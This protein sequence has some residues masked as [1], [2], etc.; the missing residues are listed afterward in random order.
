MSVISQPEAQLKSATVRSGCGAYG[1]KSSRKGARCAFWCKFLPVGP[2]GPDGV[3]DMPN[4]SRRGV[5]A[6]Q[7][8]HASVEVADSRL[9]TVPFVRHTPSLRHQS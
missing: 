8:R 5:L 9:N 3:G 2:A 1:V 4:Q 7:G 6:G